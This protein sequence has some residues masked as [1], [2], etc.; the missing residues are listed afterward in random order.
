MAQKRVSRDEWARRVRDWEASGLSAAD[1]GRRRH[2]RPGALTWWRWKLSHDEATSPAFVEVH[3]VDDV[4]D[5]PSVEVVLTN[6][7]IVRV[8][9]SFDDDALARVMSL[10]ETT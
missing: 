6:G 9:P 5:A 8:P 2:L 1:Y 10:A 7:R 3:V 4:A